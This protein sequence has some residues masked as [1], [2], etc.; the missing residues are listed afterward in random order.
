M[1]NQNFFDEA[2]EASKTK[3]SIV[4][5]YFSVWSQ[6]ILSNNK[7]DKIAYIDLYC[8]PGVYNDGTHSTP[9][10]IITKTI[11]NPTLSQKVV[12]SFN[13]KEKENIERLQ[14]EINRLENINNIANNI[15][16]NNDESNYGNPFCC[17]C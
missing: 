1:A 10:Q 11:N 5:E 3:A 13:D 6:I 16:Y 14:Q 7:I 4:S 2:S 12:F 17:R 9:L 15:T 8:G